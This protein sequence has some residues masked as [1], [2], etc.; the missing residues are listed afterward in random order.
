MVD[1]TKYTGGSSEFLK[2]SDLQQGQQF[3]VVISGDREAEFDR[4][5]K[6]QVKL[7]LA[8]HGVDK[9]LVLNATNTLTIIDQYGP[10]TEA[11]MGKELLLYSTRVPMGDKMVDAIRVSFPMQT[12]ELGGLGNYPEANR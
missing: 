1:A 3:K 10:Q 9:E 7:V 12:S 4:D 6:K 5:G 8:F 2:A 11:W